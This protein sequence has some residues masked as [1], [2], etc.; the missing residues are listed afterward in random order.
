[1]MR[2]KETQAWGQYSY[3]PKDH[4]TLL[5]I[6]V[7][8]PVMVVVVVTPQTF[9]DRQRTVSDSLLYQKRQSSC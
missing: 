9:Q 8:M 5:A 2:M 6:A 3:S 1:M 4:L 7:V